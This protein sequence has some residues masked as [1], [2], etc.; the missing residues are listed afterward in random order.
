VSSLS[1]MVIP[2]Q[3]AFGIPPPYVA[4]RPSADFRRRSPPHVL[5]AARIRPLARGPPVGTAFVIVS[6]A[7][8]I[9]RRPATAAPDACQR[10]VV[11]QSGINRIRVGAP[12][13]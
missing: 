11:T 9:L 10:T 5:M 2:F 13:R 1:A 12:T 3:T 8:P 4:F 6:A 7:V